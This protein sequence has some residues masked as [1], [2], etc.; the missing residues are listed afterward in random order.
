MAKARVAKA[1][2]EKIALVEIQAH[3]GCRAVSAV[4][5][6]YAPATKV[7]TN[8]HIVKVRFEEGTLEH[9]W[10]AVGFAHQKLRREYNLSSSS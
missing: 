8:W 9:A 10:R 5:I 1:T 2:L 4:E 7:G 6:E 3:R